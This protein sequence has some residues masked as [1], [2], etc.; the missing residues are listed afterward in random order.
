MTMMKEV[1]QD[2]LIGRTI[3]G[4]YR[5]EAKIGEGGMGRV[6]RAR[7]I[8][9]DKVVAI[10]V[11]LEDLAA[12]SSFVERFLHEAR[13]AAYITHPHA[14]NIIDCGRDGD[15]VYLLMEYIEG[16]TLTELMQQEGP[17][18][19]P[20]SGSDSQP[21]LRGSGRCARSFDCPSG[22]QTRQ[23]YSSA[24]RR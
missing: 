1:A 18:S 14:I 5:I 16:R 2:P 4:K 10:K 20:P 22:P 15:V 19:P 6:Y 11:L 12:Y 8:V 13:A 24:R 23:H 21:D 3:A 17:L 9:T 7:H